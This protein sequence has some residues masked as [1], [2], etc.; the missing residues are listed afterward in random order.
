LIA[1]SAHAGANLEGR[2]PA[3]LR[4]AGFARVEEIGQRSL[5][6]GRLWTWRATK[7]A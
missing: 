7:Q 2:L 4:E 5:G 6:F 1:H 3:L